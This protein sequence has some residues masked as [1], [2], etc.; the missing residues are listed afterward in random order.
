MF[1]GSD[2]PAAQDG[3]AV[4]PVA[5]VGEGDDGFAADAQHFETLLDI[6][7]DFQPRDTIC[8]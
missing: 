3:E 5:E 7:P 1:L 2:R 8:D 4:P 6:G